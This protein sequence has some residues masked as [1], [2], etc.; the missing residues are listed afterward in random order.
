MQAMR[1]AFPNVDEVSV[2]A[3]IA[4]QQGRQAEARGLIENWIRGCNRTERPGK[5]CY[6][7]QVYASIGEKD[8]AFEWLEKA[9]AE[10]SPLLAY[11]NVM[12]YYEALRSDPRFTAL[13]K[14]LGLGS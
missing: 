7:A 14:R 3:R 2:R 5:S 1:A 12:P 4:A 11:A 13:L 9:Y 10:R 8:L 6:A